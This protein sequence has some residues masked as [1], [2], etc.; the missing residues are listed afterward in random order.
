MRLSDCRNLF[1]LDSWQKHGFFSCEYIVSH[2]YLQA[3]KCLLSLSKLA[4]GTVTN[5]TGHTS[6]Q[7]IPPTSLFVPCLT[8][9]GTY[10][11]LINFAMTRCLISFGFMACLWYASAWATKYAGEFLYLGVGARALGMG[12]AFTAVSDDASAGYWNPAGLAK[13]SNRQALVMHAETFGELLNLDYVTLI[14]PSSQAVIGFSLMRLGGGGIKLTALEDPN[15][16][17]SEQNRVLLL[18]EEGHADY[19]FNF[20]Y[21]KRASQ[22]ASWGLNAKVI[23]RDIPQT[24]AFGLGLDFGLLYQVSRY[25]T[26]GANL[27]D[28][29]FTFLSYSTGSKETITPTLKLG[30]AIRKNWDNFSATLAG[31]SDLRFEGRE[32]SAQYW[33]GNI[34]ADNHYGLEVGYQQKL[35]GR[36]G[37]DQ[38]DFTAGAGLRVSSFTI[39]FAY[40]SE[41]ELDNSYRLSLTVIW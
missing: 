33:L 24:S 9:E 4:F 30:A 17:I 37:F 41:N 36:M 8:G 39:D 3:E 2:A 19:S 7:T 11:Y 23:Y 34:S 20:S 38:G 22:T 31:D 1:W 16:P 12:G 13:L 14:L 10:V 25:L 32:Y 27:Q 26:L 29:T 28:A 35:M 40:L 15:Q 5:P 18:R 21:G 6:L